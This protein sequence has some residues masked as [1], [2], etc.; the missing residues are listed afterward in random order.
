MSGLTFKDENEFK[1]FM[2]NLQ[3]KFEKKFE[4]PP[5][6]LTPKKEH[7]YAF[8]DFYDT[9]MN[10]S[11]IIEEKIVCSN[12]KNNIKNI[13]RKIYSVT[14]DEFLDGYNAWCKCKVYPSWN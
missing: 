5:V 4:R 6:G 9:E 1:S 14:D 2:A 10:Q 3:A 7:F 13:T 11:P 8:Y 12:Q